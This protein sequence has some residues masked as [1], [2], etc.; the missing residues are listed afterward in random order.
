MLYQRIR[1]VLLGCMFGFTCN[2]LSAQSPRLV[3]ECTITYSVDIQ[4]NDKKEETIKKLYIKG[5]KARTEISNS[6]FYQA[7]I[8]DSKNG[9][10]V[11]LK[12][13]GGD[14]YLSYF[15]AEQWRE[16]NRRWDS[17][18]VSLTKEVKKILN[19]N[20]RKAIIT[21]KDSSSYIIYFTTDLSAS[22]TEN[23]YEFRSIPGLILEYDSQT[24]NG[25]S[26]QFK[27]TDINFTPVPAAKFITP[28]TGYR[29][30]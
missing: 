23:P 4:G 20:C 8:F 11:V 13:V 24:D 14:K 3:A 5:R 22:S 16:K 27:A 17:S 21:L 15:N 2:S 30:L 25:K 29:V 9:D 18:V 12:E 6:A 19:Y 7:I 26:I 28:S 10:A 1:I